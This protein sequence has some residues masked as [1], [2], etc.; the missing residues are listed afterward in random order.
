MIEPLVWQTVCDLL[1][2]PQLIRQAWEE[3]H[4]AATDAPP[5]RV[6]QTEN[7]IKTLEQHQERLLDLFQDGQ[8]SKDIFIQRKER[9]TQ[10]RQALQQQSQQIRNQEQAAELRRTIVM[11]FTDYCQQ[12]ESSLAN[13][14]PELK[15]IPV[16]EFQAV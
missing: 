12:L 9:I 8:I 16:N 6:V 7:R 13:P 3:D 11:N 15:P 10:E 5:S 1:R 2:N 14:S 4:P